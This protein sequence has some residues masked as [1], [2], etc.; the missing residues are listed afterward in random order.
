[1]SVWNRGE[2][3]FKFADFHFSLSNFQLWKGSVIFTSLFNN[4]HHRAIR[5]PTELNLW[6][7]NLQKHKNRLSPF[8]C[9][10]TTSA[11]RSS[12]R[13]LSLIGIGSW[14]QK[15]K[16]VA[17][18]LQVNI[19][20]LHNSFCELSHCSLEE[21][22]V[23]VS[24]PHAKDIH[25][26]FFTPPSFFSRAKALHNLGLRVSPRLTPTPHVKLKDRGT[27]LLHSLQ[28]CNLTTGP[29]L[30]SQGELLCCVKI[31]G[32]YRQKGQ[33]KQQTK[34]QPTTYDDVTLR[35]PTSVTPHTA[36]HRKPAP[37]STASS[38]GSQHN[39]IALPLK[40]ALFYFTRL[41]T[42]VTMVTQRG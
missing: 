2:N 41:L 1:M 8:L 4:L 9:R 25:C 37:H 32:S 27:C 40:K 13:C 17:V 19:V 31:P 38:R 30:F 21:D 33:L 29:C 36:Q 22:E 23:G 16:K 11:S 3:S 12:S 5:E 10:L 20:I 42:Y 15:E 39:S 26:V 18:L 14:R 7:T 24:P 6:L 34:K 35:T 28:Y